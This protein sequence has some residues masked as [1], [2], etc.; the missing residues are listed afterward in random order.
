MASAKSVDLIGLTVFDPV[1]TQV[2]AT[3]SPP[4][5]RD[6]ALAMWQTAPV[7]RVDTPPD[8]WPLARNLPTARLPS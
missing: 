2:K 8:F 7:A 1:L 3:G 4:P 6:A 5:A